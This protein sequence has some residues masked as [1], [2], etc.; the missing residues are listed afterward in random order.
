MSRGGDL[1]PHLYG[2]L[3]LSAVRWAKPLPLGAH[4]RHDFPELSA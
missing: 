3:P 4:G 2:E 1:F